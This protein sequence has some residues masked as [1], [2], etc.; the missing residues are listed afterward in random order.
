MATFKHILSKNF[1]FSVP[2]E[3]ARKSLQFDPKGFYVTEEQKEIDYIRN[4]IAKKIDPALKEVKGIELVNKMKK[5]EVAKAPEK[6]KEV[7]KIVEEQAKFSCEFCG[8]ET[9]NKGAL[10]NHIRMKHPEKVFSK[11]KK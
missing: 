7:E 6:A 1:N 4:F 10:K 8:K 3:V 9:G 5:E 2:K 11:K